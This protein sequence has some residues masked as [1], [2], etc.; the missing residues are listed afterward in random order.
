MRRAALVIVIGLLGTTR[1]AGAEPWA[2]TME[3]G[4]EADSNVLRDATGSGAM[5][6][7][8]AAP[9]GRAGARLDRKDRVLDGAYT[10]GVSGLSRMVASS[11]DLTKRENVMLYA[12]DA[13]WVRGIGSRPIAAGFGLVAADAFRIGG[14]EG[15][16][17]FRN[18]GGD[19]LL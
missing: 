16:R 4:G 13:R 3:A 12:A 11:N 14:G 9:V 2:L 6:G 8:I 19:A 5:R 7:A 1:H 10:I 18:L 17:T 15:A